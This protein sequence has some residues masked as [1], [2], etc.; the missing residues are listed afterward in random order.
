M[1]EIIHTLGFIDDNDE[2]VIMGV[3]HNANTERIVR[4]T[5]GEEITAQIIESNARISEMPPDL[6]GHILKGGA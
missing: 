3:I 4:F 1:K 2:I 5:L 6:I